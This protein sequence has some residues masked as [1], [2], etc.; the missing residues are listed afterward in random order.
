MKR[1]R[2]I[3]IV[4]DERVICDLLAELLEEEGYRV[5]R[6]YDGVSGLASAELRR[7]DLILTDVMMPGID[8]VTLIRRLRERGVRA[9][10]VLMSAVYAEIDLPGVRFVPKPFDVD[11]IL[12]VVERLFRSSARSVRRANLSRLWHSHSRARRRRQSRLQLPLLIA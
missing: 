11:D 8:G 6:A 12:D 2:S 1:E 5:I 10:A 7:P 3:L 4:D 9:P